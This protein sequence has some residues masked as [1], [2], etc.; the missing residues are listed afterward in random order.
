MFRCVICSSYSVAFCAG[1]REHYVCDTEVNLC[2]SN[3]CGHGGQCL[4]KEGGYSCVCKLGFAG[5]NCQVDL[6]RDSCLAGTSAGVACG[7]QSQCISRPPGGIQCANC[8]SPSV[9]VND[10]CQL[11]SR[12]FY[13]GSFLTFPALRQ[14]HRFHLKLR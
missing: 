14:R 10:L 3:P 13:R 11:R 6:R 4:R 7:S 1:M 2:Y 8:T 12:S 9:F 5:I